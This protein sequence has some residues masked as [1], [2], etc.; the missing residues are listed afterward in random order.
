MNVYEKEHEYNA[1]TKNQHSSPRLPKEVTGLCGSKVFIV[2]LLFYL[3]MLALSIIVKEKS[4]RAYSPF[5][6]LTWNLYKNK[7]L[8]NA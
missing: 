4:P 8:K 6:L 5:C 7:K 3:S 2:T 1:C